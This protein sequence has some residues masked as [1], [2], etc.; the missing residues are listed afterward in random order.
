MHQ[1]KSYHLD[2]G[3][4]RGSLK[5]FEALSYLQGHGTKAFRAHRHTYYQL[6]WFDKPGQHFIDFKT[7]SHPANSLFFV[8]KGQV[9]YFCDQ[10]PNQGYLFHFN[11]EFLNRYEF[12][13]ENWSHY[14]LFHALTAPFIQLSNLQIGKVEQIRNLIFEELDKKEFNFEK[15][16]Y[17][18]FRLLL[19]NIERE[20]RS[21]NQKLVETGGDF[22]LVARFHQLAEENISQNMPIDYYAGELGISVKKLSK[23]SAELIG[24]SPANIISKK[25]AVEAKRLLSNSNLSIKE[26]GYK[27][28]FNQATYFTKFF[29]KHTSQTPKEFRVSIESEY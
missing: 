3:D 28:G 1:I 6:I 25:K 17:F 11:D 18:L 26:I 15:Q 14:R 7:Y 22:H 8:D 23:L 19:L 20:K 10:S 5:V 29:K 27:L 12:S 21:Q 4:D 13:N 9:H 16:T 24:D 2:E